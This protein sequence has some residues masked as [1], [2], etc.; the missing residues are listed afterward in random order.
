MDKEIQKLIEEREKLRLEL[1]IELINFKKQKI[2][3]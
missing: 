2:K 1:I 3:I